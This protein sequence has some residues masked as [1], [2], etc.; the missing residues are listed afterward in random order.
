VILNFS[1]GFL[2]H[3]SRWPRCNSIHTETSQQGSPLSRSLL[4]IRGFPISCSLS[5]SHL[6]QLPRATISHCA[7][8]PPRACTVP[9]PCQRSVH[10]SRGSVFP[11]WVPSTSFSTVGKLTNHRAPAYI[12]S[13]QE[14]KRRWFRI[15]RRNILRGFL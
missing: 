1:C 9:T 2:T 15:Q 4:G 7:L 12:G 11:K 14:K 6:P 8:P 13:L 3:L 5:P 10:A